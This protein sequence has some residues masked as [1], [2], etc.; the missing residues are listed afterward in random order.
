MIF[1]QSSAHFYSTIVSSQIRK[2]NP[3]KASGSDG[4][5]GQMLKICD[6]SVVLP[7]RIIFKNILD[8]S[9]YP[10]MW[11]VADVTPIFKKEDK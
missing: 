4:I 8:T 6:T 10:D 7:L 11:K 1:S 3:N 9:V 2:I 5:S